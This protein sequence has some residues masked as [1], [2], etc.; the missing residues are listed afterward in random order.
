MEIVL[1]RA[2]MLIWA[3]P[4]WNVPNVLLIIV[5]GYLTFHVVAFWVHDMKKM[6]S[7][8][9]TVGTLYSLALVGVLVFGVGLRWI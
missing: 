2:D 6:R 4:F 9:I 3:Y 7:K 8:L 1:N 5:F